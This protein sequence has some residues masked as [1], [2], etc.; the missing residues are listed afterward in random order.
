M[1]ETMPGN[2]LNC[3]EFK[4]CGREPGG[5]YSASGGACI[6]SVERRADGVN[7]GN[8]GGRACW[9]I[10]GTE[11]GGK[12]QGVFAQKIDSCQNCEFYLKVMDEEYPT[13]MSTKKILAR[14]N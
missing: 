6:A 13:Y 9:A 4:R 14:L 3:W 5:A 2:K 10:T 12:P 11:C 8:N 7:S 1:E